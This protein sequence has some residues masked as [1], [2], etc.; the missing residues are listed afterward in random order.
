MTQNKKCVISFRE[1]LRKILFRIELFE[2]D[3]WWHFTGADSWGLFPPS[4]YRLHTKEEIERIRAET[5]E[6]LLKL[7]ND[8]EP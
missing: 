2:M 6:M 7:I 1:L 5:L 3:G 8:E 4:F